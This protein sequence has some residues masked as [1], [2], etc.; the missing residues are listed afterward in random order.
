MSELNVLND[1]FGSRTELVKKRFE[2]SNM[3]G[4]VQAANSGTVPHQSL[5]ANNKRW[6]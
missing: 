6:N 3:Q 1:S 5:H 4:T 2:A